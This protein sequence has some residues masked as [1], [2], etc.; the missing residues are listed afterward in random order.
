MKLNRFLNCRRTAVLL[1]DNSTPATKI[2]HLFECVR[3]YRGNVRF[4]VCKVNT[5]YPEVAPMC[6]KNEVCVAIQ[7]T[8]EREIDK[9]GA[10]NAAYER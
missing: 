4:V 8:A 2:K 10:T 7:S 9:H 6:G 5:D 1:D 3:R